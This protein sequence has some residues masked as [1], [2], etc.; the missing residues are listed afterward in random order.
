M[1]NLYNGLNIDDG[2]ENKIFTTAL[3][4]HKTVKFD[5]EML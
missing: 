3:P 5:C 2:E 4:Q 1:D